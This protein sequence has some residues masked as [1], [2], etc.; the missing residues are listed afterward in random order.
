MSGGF[1]CHIRCIFV[2]GRALPQLFFQ[3]NLAPFLPAGDPVFE[4][5]LYALVAQ[6]FTV[7]HLPYLSQGF[8]A[9]GLKIPALGIFDFYDNPC[10]P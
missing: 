3:H 2:K 9:C 10:A 1:G 8:L 5:G 7:P 4:D 6:E